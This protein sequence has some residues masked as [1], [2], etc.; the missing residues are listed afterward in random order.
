MDIHS[1]KTTDFRLEVCRDGSHTVFSE[2]F[3]QF[4]HNPNG[5][6]AESWH[7][8]FDQS[9]LR[10]RLMA[11]EHV[12]ILEIG[13][14]TG[15]NL[16]LLCELMAQV[17]SRSEVLFQSVEAWPVSPDIVSQFNYSE[18]LSR[19]DGASRLVG[20]FEQLGSGPVDT[21][22]TEQV[23]IRVHRGLFESMSPVETGFQYVFHDAFSPGVN[24]ELWTTEVF[25]RIRSWCADSAWL[26]T[27]CAAT[28]A[29]NAMRDA[30]WSVNKA[31]GALGKREMTIARK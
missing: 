31:P 18:F 2:Q 20:I 4:F 22:F 9:D 30:G 7:I 16:L 26:T 11:H 14:G 3:G 17:G 12:R 15:L 28:R 27:Y 23:R 21:E 19:F 25:E 13:F 24:P 5:A 8:F 6:V 1:K 29:R 10:A